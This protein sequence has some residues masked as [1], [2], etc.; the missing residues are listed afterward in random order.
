MSA[1]A[2]PTVTY[3]AIGVVRSPF[4]ELDGMPLQSVAAEDVRGQIEVRP[5][6]RPALK[7]LDGFSHVWVVSHLHRSEPPTV[8]V[9][10]PF[11]D[12]VERGLF[13]TRSPR[14]PNPIGLSV[15]RLLGIEGSTLQ[16]SGLDLLDGTPVLDLK[17]YVPLFDGIDAERIGWLTHRADQVHSI[18]ADRRFDRHD[19]PTLLRRPCV[20]DVM[21]TNPKT[22]PHDATV[23][24]IRAL[25]EH[26]SVRLALLVNEGVCIGTINRA[27]IPAD[28]RDEDA[29]AAFAQ[30]PQT[31]DADASLAEAH[32][33]LGE[34]EDRRLLVL[35]A[36]GRLQGLLCHKGS[37]SGFCSNKSSC[38][39][40]GEAVAKSRWRIVRWSESGA[41]EEQP[42]LLV[43]PEGKAISVG[44][45]LTL[46]PDTQVRWLV[47]GVDDAPGD[48]EGGIAAVEAFEP[49]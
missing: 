30:A 3:D 36:E 37:R 10:L 6:F 33:Q 46:P 27:A 28:A 18:R 38:D 17:P 2:F 34:T 47:V 4:T 22:Q 23:G 39:H 45:L 26:R 32:R 31:I 49:V 1:P 48:A 21:D 5:E 41:G 44:D 12:D 11:L 25:F 29:A 40:R 7:D 35:D 13:A 19:M 8:S 14:H 20:R 42:G 15:V 16:V 9:V 24:E 43:A